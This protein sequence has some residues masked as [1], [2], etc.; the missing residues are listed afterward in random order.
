MSFLKKIGGFL[1]GGFLKE[2]S[3][4][5]DQLITTKEEKE[6]LRQ[7]MQQL[8]QEHEAALLRLANED[9]HSAR[10][11]QK[12]ALAQE[13]PFSKRFVYYLAGLWSV[14]G[15]VYV[16]LVTF[17]EVVNARTADTVLG[18][19]MG[20]IVSTIINYFFGAS[21]AGGFGGSVRRTKSEKK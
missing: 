21:D 9:R 15:I 1:S 10:D 13:D 5:I 12:A 7:A 14:A 18:F 6:K 11:M 4:L 16:F 20:T 17:T 19:L 2:A 8:V 3:Q